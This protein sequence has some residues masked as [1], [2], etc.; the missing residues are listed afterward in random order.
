MST[1]YEVIC[2]YTPEQWS[3]VRAI[4]S[5][6]D[7]M[8]KTFDEWLEHVQLMVKRFESDGAAV[9]KVH[10]DADALLTFAGSAN[11]NI[12]DSGI[13]KKFALERY[14]GGV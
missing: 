8:G 12:I 13:R 9:T 7:A 6:G 14:V 1:R 2:W 11:A 4:S 5:D 10:V 3:K